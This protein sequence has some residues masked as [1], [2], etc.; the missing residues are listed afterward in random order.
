MLGRPDTRFDASGPDALAAAAFHL[1]VRAEV[2]RRCAEVALAEARKV[3]E[4]LRAAAAGFTPPGG[5][6]EL[7]PPEWR[8]HLVREQRSA[9]EVGL[10]LSLTLVPTPPAGADFWAVATALARATDF[11][12]RFAQAP[13][14]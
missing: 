14:G 7:A 1:P 2:R 13:R 9:N 5:R 8:S 11:A 10:S 3:A 6:L 4:E 12:E